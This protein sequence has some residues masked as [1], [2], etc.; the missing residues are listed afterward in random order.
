[1]GAIVTGVTSVDIGDNSARRRAETDW[2]LEAI[3][4]AIAAG[5]LPPDDAAAWAKIAA[6]E[7]ELLGLTPHVTPGP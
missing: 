6:C 1:M 3:V 5:K 7:V 2:M 4:G